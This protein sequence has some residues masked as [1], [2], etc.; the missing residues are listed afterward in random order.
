ME[1]NYGILYESPLWS[2]KF[3]VIILKEQRKAKWA[4]HREKIRRVHE[5]G[6][7]AQCQVLGIQLLVLGN[8]MY[9][10]VKES[11]IKTLM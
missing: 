7:I 8:Q 3:Q 10:D 1:E 11:V 2:E 5:V 4:D 6:H 9:L